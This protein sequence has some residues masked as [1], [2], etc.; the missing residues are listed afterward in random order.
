MSKNQ[1]KQIISTNLSYVILPLLPISFTCFWK[2]I[3]FHGTVCFLK[4]SKFLRKLL[5]NNN[6]NEESC[7]E[8]LDR[9]KTVQ[10]SKNRKDSKTRIEEYL[11]KSARNKNSKTSD[12][13]LDEEELLQINEISSIHSLLAVMPLN[14]KDHKN[15]SYLVKI[16]KN[17]KFYLKILKI[18]LNDENL[19]DQTLHDL[20]LRNAG[21]VYYSNF[22]I[23]LGIITVKT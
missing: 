18:I 23:G 22:F 20:D 8:I 12:I 13:V 16:F 14:E 15:D 3:T 17:L 7:S 1:F 6:K 21:F 9:I 10:C 5:L 4:T 11:M 2:M 19:M